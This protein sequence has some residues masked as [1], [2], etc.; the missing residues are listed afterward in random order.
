[1][2]KE[3]NEFRSLSSLAISIFQSDIFILF[4]ALLTGIIVAR[5]LGPELLGVWVLLSLISL[6]SEAFGRL[7]T[8][9][10]SIYIIGSGKAKS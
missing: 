10:A 7:K 4:L 5:T 9:I 3:K 6:Y 1:M 8:D 2:Q